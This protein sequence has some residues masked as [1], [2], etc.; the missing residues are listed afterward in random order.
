MS[1][2]MIH[3]V[4]FYSLFEFGIEEVTRGDFRSNIGRNTFQARHILS[5]DLIVIDEV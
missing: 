2:S 4:I 5:A 1:G 3:F